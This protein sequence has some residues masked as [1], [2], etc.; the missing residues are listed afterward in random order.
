VASQDQAARKWQHAKNDIEKQLRFL[1]EKSR[2]EVAL[3]GLTRG[4]R[5]GGE[6]GMRRGKSTPTGRIVSSSF[7]F[8]HA[9]GCGL[10]HL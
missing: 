9:I 8:G 2:M 6:Q 10:A 5:I 3:A 4:I 1:C 7:R